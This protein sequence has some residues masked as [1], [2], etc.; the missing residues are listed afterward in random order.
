MPSNT[1][2]VQN[3]RLTGRL[4]LCGTQLFGRT[5][6]L[7]SVLT[8]RLHGN[9]LARNPVTHNSCW[10]VTGARPRSSQRRRRPRPHR[11]YGIAHVA[12]QFC[13][14]REGAQGNWL[15]RRSSGDWSRKTGVRNDHPRAQFD[16]PIPRSPDGQT[17]LRPVKSIVICEFRFVNLP[18]QIGNHNSQFIIHN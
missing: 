7:R 17:A 9:P 5:R 3:R 6:G 8:Q 4:S 15:N 12:S 13:R 1:S 16:D 14:L 18:T 10:A 11:T 2:A